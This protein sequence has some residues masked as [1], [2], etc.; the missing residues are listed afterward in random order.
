VVV[1]SSVNKVVLVVVVELEVVLV[2]GSAVVLVVAGKVV[3]VS[4]AEELKTVLQPTA[5]T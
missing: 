2:E 1:T 5:K 4:K 3:A